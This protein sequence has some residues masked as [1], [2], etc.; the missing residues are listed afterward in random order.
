MQILS[1][2]GRYELFWRLGISVQKTRVR[3]ILAWTLIFPFSSAFLK[4]REILSSNFLSSHILTVA[5]IFSIS[6]KTQGFGRK[7]QEGIGELFLLSVCDIF[8]S[9][10]KHQLDSLEGE[11][12]E[13]SS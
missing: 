13:E 4:A 2:F 9:R 3:V 12:Q 1:P 8:F 10:E 6:L 11:R 7:G 5:Q